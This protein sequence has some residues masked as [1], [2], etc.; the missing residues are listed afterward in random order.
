[1]IQMQYNAS[2]C[3][4]V[5]QKFSGG[6]TPDLILVL[7]P[8]IG[9]PPLQNSGC[10]PDSKF[11]CTRVKYNETSTDLDIFFVTLRIILLKTFLKTVLI[12]SPQVKVSLMITPKNLLLVSCVIV[13]LSI[14]I[15]VISLKG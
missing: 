4:Y 7:G 1:M 3:M 12:S 10:A 8:R 6:D 15:S 5:L 9:P 2:K 11:G 14:F 13:I